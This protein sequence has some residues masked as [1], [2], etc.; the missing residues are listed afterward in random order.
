MSLHDFI[1]VVTCGIQNL[2]FLVGTGRIGGRT[3][4]M[5]FCSGAAGQL[6]FAESAR[7]ELLLAAFFFRE[8]TTKVDEDR[9]VCS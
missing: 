8:E 1:L 7:K 6:F 4:E 3:V 2:F 5:A 9:R